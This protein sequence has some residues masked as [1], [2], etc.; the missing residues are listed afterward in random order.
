[1]RE[2]NFTFALHVRT[3]HVCIIVYVHIA[4]FLGNYWK[5][6]SHLHVCMA[7]DTNALGHALEG[8]SLSSR[9]AVLCNTRYF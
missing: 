5:G 9:L 8:T 3:L 2:G 7:M 1:M 4:F 6:A